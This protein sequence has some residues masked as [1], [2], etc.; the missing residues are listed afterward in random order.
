M[1]LTDL[2][3]RMSDAMTRLTHCKGENDAT[4]DGAKINR[5]ETARELIGPPH[6]ENDRLIILQGEMQRHALLMD[7]CQGVHDQI[8]SAGNEIRH[9]ANELLCRAST[10][11]AMQSLIGMGADV[12]SRPE[13]FVLNGTVLHFFVSKGLHEVVDVLLAHNAEVD[14]T[15]GGF[16]PLHLACNAW[17]PNMNVIRSL[18]RAGANEA[19]LAV[20]GRTP[21]AMILNNRN[22]I[23][24]ILHRASRL[25][26]LV[27]LPILRMR[28]SELRIAVRLSLRLPGKRT[29]LA[30][31]FLVNVAPDGV[32]GK[33][34]S[35]L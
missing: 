30:V 22:E 3:G 34:V 24:R 14:S 29:A 28:G 9:M 31:I 19:T 10:P 21:E 33:V 18:L 6:P 8:V 11:D 4:W 5:S 15:F 16:T 32:F 13:G 1:A 25:R 35:F 12:N 27:W 26:R 7:D 2:L 23:C 20:D 17:D